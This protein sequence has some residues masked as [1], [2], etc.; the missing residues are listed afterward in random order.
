[1]S[2]D[3]RVDVVAPA[4]VEAARMLVTRQDPTSSA[5]EGVGLLTRADDG[6]TFRY[7]PRVR[8]LSSF[9][10]LIGFPDLA[11]TYRSPRLFPLF[12][13][14]IMRESRPDFADHLHDIG[15]TRG[16]TPWERLGRTQG[17]RVGDRIRVISEPAVDGEGRSHAVFFVNGLRHVLAVAP[18]TEHVLGRLNEGDPLQLV[19]EP[20]NP[21]DERAVV[22]SADGA[23]VGWV[24]RVLLDHVDAVQASGEWSLVVAA[25]NGPDSP[26]PFR[27][28]VR[29]DGQPGRGHDAFAALTADI[30]AG[31][32]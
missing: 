16:A 28:R 9:P 19:A 6:F 30:R 1:M 29:L 22:V 11:A 23:P 20:D 7:L 2:S 17:E 24:P 26:P 31:N 15:L 10:A 18:A 4:D 14:R 13:E 12:A 21:V 3:A 8:Q 27:L 5:H 32:T 25:V